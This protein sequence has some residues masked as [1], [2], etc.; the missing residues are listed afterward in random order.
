ML[1]CPWSHVGMLFTSPFQH[2]GKFKFFINIVSSQ[3]SEPGGFF[4]CT[5]GDKKFSPIFLKTFSKQLA[6]NNYRLYNLSLCRGLQNSL[7][8]TPC[9]T[10]L[11]PPIKMK[12]GT[13]IGRKEKRWRCTKKRV[14]VQ[15]QNNLK[16]FMSSIFVVPKKLSGFQSLLILKRLNSCSEYNHFK[17]LECSYQTKFKKS[18]SSFSLGLSEMCE[19]LMERKTVPISLSAF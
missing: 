18:L 2:R 10:Q 3:T 12:G 19:F 15:V 11:P 17:W 4:K 9:Q 6:R 7:P 14:V 1:H 8:T 13:N 5:S 16:Q